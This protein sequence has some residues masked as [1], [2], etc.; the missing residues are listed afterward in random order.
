MQAQYPPFKELE[1]PYHFY[2]KSTPKNIQYP[3]KSAYLLYILN[4][5]LL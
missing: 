5:A 4:N 1:T 2:Y 3:F